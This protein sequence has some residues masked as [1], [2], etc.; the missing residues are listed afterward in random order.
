MRFNADYREQ[1]TLK[2]GRQTVIRLLRPE[3]RPKLAAGFANLSEDGRYRRFLS[4]KTK[5]TEAELDYL[6][7]LDQQTHFAIGALSVNPSEGIGVARFIVDPNDP[8]IADP[9]ITVLDK[10]QG[11]G[12]GTALFTR[13]TEAAIERGIQRFRGQILATNEAM[14]AIMHGMSTDASTTVKGGV[15]SVEFALVDVGASSAEDGHRD[16]AHHLRRQLIRP[17]ASGGAILSRF[18]TW[19]SELDDNT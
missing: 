19:L 4:P 14:M 16:A 8:T 15:A 3:D 18:L 12:L 11:I 1:L 9:A 7:N 2:D 5:L 6:T 13:L 10:A 17:F